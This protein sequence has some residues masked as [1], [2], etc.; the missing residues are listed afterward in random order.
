MSH[1]KKEN[2][3]MTLTE[4]VKTLCNDQTAFA[5]YAEQPAAE[6]N[7]L[8]Q[9]YWYEKREKVISKVF[10]KR[11]YNLIPEADQMHYGRTIGQSIYSGI[12]VKITE[13]KILLL[14]AI[15]SGEKFPTADGEDLNLQQRDYLLY[16]GSLYFVGDIKNSAADIVFNYQNNVYLIAP[17]MEEFF[18]QPLPQRAVR[19]L[20]S[21]QERMIE[22]IKEVKGW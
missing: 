1:D 21:L 17:K 18:E 12:G 8:R 6:S 9:F 5:Q 16:F 19:C 10:E 4:L 7:T 13:E 14:E 3:K 20:A 22:R 11:V 15:L 2:T